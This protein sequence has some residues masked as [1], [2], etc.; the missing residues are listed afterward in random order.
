MIRQF[1]EIT[2]GDNYSLDKDPNVSLVRRTGTDRTFFTNWM[3]VLT[4]NVRKYGTNLITA[5]L[6][7]IQIPL[8]HFTLSKNIEAYLL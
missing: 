5:Q 2:T 7:F 6:P 8:I 3:I 1:S 4:N